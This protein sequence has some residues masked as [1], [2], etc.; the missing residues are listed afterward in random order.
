VS[1]THL[2]R[3]LAVLAVLLALLVAVC[4]MLPTPNTGRDCETVPSAQPTQ[5]PTEQTQPET[6]PQHPPETQPPTIASTQAH[7]PADDT[8]VR[9]ADYVPNLKEALAYATTENFTGRKIYDFTECYLRYGTVKKLA[10][11]AELL[12]QQGLGIVIWDGYRPL[13]AQQALWEA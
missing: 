8:F 3:I 9:A 12:L 13:Y 1:V 4:F 2:K 7:E 11:A 10:D 5:L 6:F